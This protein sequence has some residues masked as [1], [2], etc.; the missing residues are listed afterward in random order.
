MSKFNKIILIVSGD[1]IGNKMAGPGMR[2]FNIANILSGIFSNVVLACPNQVGMDFKLAYP[3][4]CF[5]YYESPED[6][7][8]ILLK[9]SVDF[10][11]VQNLSFD[12]VYHAMKNKVKIIY[13][14][15]N[16]S[17]IEYTSELNHGGKSFQEGYRSLLNS[18]F[19]YAR[20]GSYFVAANERQRD[21]WM[22]ILAQGGYLIPEFKN[23][24]NNIDSIIGLLPFGISNSQPVKTEKAL[25]N[26][27]EGIDDKS[28]II[29]WTGGVWDW[30][31]PI[32]VIK[33]VKELYLIN[34][35]IKMVFYGV[36]HPNKSVKQKNMLDKARKLSDTLGLTGL[37]IFFLDGWVDNIKRQNY[38]LESDI[39]VSAHFDTLETRYSFRTRIL[40]HFWAEKPTVCTEGDYF[41]KEIEER[42]LGYTVKYRDVEGW[43]DAILKVINEK[44]HTA[45]IIKNIK[46][47]RVNYYWSNTC[48][49]LVKY[50][51]DDCSS[52]FENTD[53]L[54]DYIDLCSI[55]NLKEE[56]HKV[57]TAKHAKED[58][59]KILQK[60][61]INSIRKL[62]AHIKTFLD[63]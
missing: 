34:P 30:F 41:A 27:I 37:C 42:K 43:K 50:M 51:A 22:G 61:S 29:L 28:K 35:N 18:T 52:Q 21:F 8:N 58:I 26:V 48:A 36:Q 44:N 2:Y 31:D 12:V 25:R 60:P 1:V 45:E 54:N 19:L 20:S 14:L 7:I 32:T 16:P 10:I 33:A 59:I 47:Y 17:P 13:D 15:Y 55:Q 63:F 4:I 62:K 3:S 5:D 56:S 53:R 40:D 46:K 39:L 57:L 6:V 24:V 49:C 11:F 23:T 38:L 9:N